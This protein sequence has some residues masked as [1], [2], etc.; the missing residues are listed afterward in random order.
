MLHSIVYM[1]VFWGPIKRKQPT[2][3][4]SV[5]L[6]VRLFKVSSLMT[7]HLLS[8]LVYLETL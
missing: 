1:S 3:A 8:L 4:L 7:F 2:R 5:A 6:F